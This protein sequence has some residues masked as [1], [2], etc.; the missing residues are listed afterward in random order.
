[1]ATNGALGKTQGTAVIAR[2]DGGETPINLAKFLFRFTLLV[3][4]KYE[5]HRH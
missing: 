2:P 4:K 3:Y 5:S 1:M